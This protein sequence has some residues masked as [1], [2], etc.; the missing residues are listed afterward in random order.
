MSGKPYYPNNWKEYKDAPDDF[1]I[2]HTF[3]EV[4]DWK[5]GQ[6]ELPS[7]VECIIRTKDTRTHKVK[8]YTYQKLSAAR[9]KV[10]KL[11]RQPDLEITVCDHQAIHFLTDVHPLEDYED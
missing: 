8:E 10:D 3:D 6:W 5:V 9:A 7:S 2:P 4:M 1:F 11:V